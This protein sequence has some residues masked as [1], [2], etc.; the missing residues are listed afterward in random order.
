MSRVSADK[1]SVMDLLTKE[2][3]VGIVCR[4]EPTL[5]RVFLAVFLFSLLGLAEQASGFQQASGPTSEKSAP[6]AVSA[7]GTD[8]TA[9]VPGSSVQ[10]FREL[11]FFQL[12]PVLFR[13]SARIHYYYESNLFATPGSN[14]GTHGVA[15]EPTL[16]A[17]IPL[18]ANGIRLDYSP[19]FRDY[20][21]FD[22]NHK[23]S[24][25]FNADSRLDLTPVLNVSVREHFTMASLETSEYVPA[26]EVIFSDAQFKRN[27]ISTQLNWALT[28]NNAVGIIGDWNHV[29][30]EESAS[31][32][33]RPF[34]DYNQYSLGGVYRRDVS[35]RT[36]IFVNGTYMRD[37]AD[38]PRNI[39]SS[40]GFET[41]VGVESQLTPL[42]SGQLSMGYRALSFDGAKDQ[43]Y[44]GAVI[45]GSLSKE[46]S[47]TIRVGVAGTRS[48]NLSNF[49]R[50]AYYLTHGIGF[51]YQ[52]MFG[53]DFLIAVNPAYQRNTYALPLAPRAGITADHRVDGLYDLAV[54]AR[55]RVTDLIGVEARYDLLHRSSVLPELRFTNYRAGVSLL[56]GQRGITTGR[57]R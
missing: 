8:T 3:I 15:L 44:K 11:R 54:A 57:V 48:T 39:A 34:F 22:L 29:A 46:L 52:Q 5:K 16:E 45:R 38:D 12:G 32:E 30:F 41:L 49:E 1:A 9:Y 23:M 2:I 28:D 18:T 43:N 6:S 50:N 40:D 53:P 24:H 25:T 19:T 21:N 26:R 37:Q 17:F 14:S 56:I 36:G 42:T 35:P 4:A 27:S 13:P 51:T 33:A 55:Y 10:H 47:E 7:P 20:S 31:S